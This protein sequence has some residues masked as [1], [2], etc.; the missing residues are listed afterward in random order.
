MKHIHTFES[1]LSENH[2]VNEGEDTGRP[3]INDYAIRVYNYEP[4]WKVN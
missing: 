1:F 2:K 3:M 4:N